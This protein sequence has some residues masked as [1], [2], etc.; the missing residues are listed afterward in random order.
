[1]TV[2]GQRWPHLF[3]FVLAVLGS[4]SCARAKVTQVPDGSHRIVCERGMKICV[5]RAEKLCGDDGY[6]ILSG[7][8]H[9]KLLGGSSSSYQQLAANGELFVM[10]GDVETPELS[11]K[12]AIP[13][14]PRNDEAAPHSPAP[15]VCTPG[16]TQQCVGAGAC[17]GGQTCLPGGTGFG[18]CDCGEQSRPGDAATQGKLPGAPGAPSQPPTVPARMPEPEPLDAGAGAP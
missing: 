15:G 16:A 10:C 12:P 1:M 4:V 9:M 11:Q 14:P 3:G 6:T 2:S 17:A 18:P 13:L 5:A 7:R 8:T